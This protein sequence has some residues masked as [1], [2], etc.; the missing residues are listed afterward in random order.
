MNKKKMLRAAA[1]LILGVGI[2]TVSNSY[3][4]ST[5][6]LITADAVSRSK[7]VSE[8]SLLADIGLPP[9]GTA[10]YG[11]TASGQLVAAP[12]MIQSG[13]EAEDYVNLPQHIARVF[14]HFFD[15]QYNGYAGRGLTQYG[16]TIGIPS[17]DWALEDQG[18]V[19]T[20][21]V[22]LRN[23]PFLDLEE[24]Y[25]Q[26]G[27][28]PQANSFRHGQEAY[29][30]LL[31]GREPSYRQ[32][33]A[34][35]M[36]LSLGSVVHHLQDMAQPQHVRNERH[37]DLPLSYYE[38]YTDAYVN[39]RIQPFLANTYPVP[40]FDTARQYWYSVQSTADHV[41]RYLGMAE[42]TSNNFISATTGYIGNSNG[43][44]SA[45]APYALPNGFNADGTRK[46]IVSQPYSITYANG[47]TETDTAEFVIGTVQD[48]LPTPA[49]SAAP[50]R[51]AMSSLLD[52][53]TG[54][55]A[56]FRSFTVSP[57][58]FEDGYPVL[59]PRASAFSSGMINH[60]FR[61]RLN[62][63]RGANNAGWVVT[64][65]SRSGQTMQG[66]LKLFY[67]NSLGNRYP[68]PNGAFTIN[69]ASGAAN[70]LTVEPPPDATK[71]IAAFAGRIGS[72]G[73]PSGTGFFAVAGKVIAYTPPTVPTPCPTPLAAGGGI[74]SSSDKIIEME[75]GSV[76]GLVSGEFEAGAFP[77]SLVVRRGSATGPVLFS[78]APSVLGLN[79]FS[80][81]HPAGLD[82]S[83]NRIHIR[84]TSA[85][86]PSVVPYGVSWLL[87][88]SCPGQP[89]QTR[90]QP[91]TTISFHHES[92]G[93]AGCPYGYYDI[94]L[95]E[96]KRAQ[97]S[98]GQ[99]GGSGTLGIEVTAN[100]KHLL[101][102]V[103]V[104]ESYG[105]P[106]VGCVI[107]GPF[108]STSLHSKIMIGSY[109]GTLGEITFP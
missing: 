66:S 51:L 29:Y 44:V 71:V 94:Y 96:V 32:A 107:G 73:D 77:G 27:G 17:P 31:T 90:Q 59:L 15:V 4:V 85:P 19:A 8:S 62:L 76:G 100:I 52:R 12:A 63:T 60:F 33:Q 53:G 14:N 11:P 69:L 102:L 7:L 41:P 22:D 61:G 106:V 23:I 18:N 89:I 54:R 68:V 93:G 92:S 47:V 57:A 20:I 43:I 36:F 42:F 87:N 75:L 40:Q 49:V 24:E 48:G 82:A 1:S 58:V 67:E 25:L 78:T 97:V 105:Q 30:E 88:V 80:F 2:A 95:D 38:F 35:Q 21:D 81:Q 34:S 74:T 99:I 28:M 37:N 45:R 86:N 103:R 64:N 56:G 9:L 3:E 109:V 91:L 13:A 65:A 84:L 101:R 5:H 6:L 104:T 72:E 16:Q 50:R 79:K 83:Q 98:F 26:Y 39:Q 55:Y 108:V 10:S 46:T 70:S